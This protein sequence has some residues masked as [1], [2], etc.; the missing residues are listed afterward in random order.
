M[1]RFDA[2]KFPLSRIKVGSERHR[3]DL[4]DIEG[5]ATASRMLAFST[6]LS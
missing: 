6:S 5:L 4:G 2:Q 3:K 1:P